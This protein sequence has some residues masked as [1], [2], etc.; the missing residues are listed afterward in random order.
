MLLLQ[1]LWLQ[2]NC[3]LNKWL[4]QHCKADEADEPISPLS[5]TGQ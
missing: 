3:E 4:L 5:L 1:Q 2:Q